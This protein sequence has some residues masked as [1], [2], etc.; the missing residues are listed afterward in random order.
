M[1]EYMDGWIG[2]SMTSAAKPISR[3][4]HE[5]MDKSRLHLAAV[6]TCT[7]DPPQKKVQ[8]Q[9]IHHNIKKVSTSFIRTLRNRIYLTAIH[10]L[11]SLPLH[12]SSISPSLCSPCFPI[13]SLPLH[14]AFPPPSPSPSSCFSFSVR[15]FDQWP[16]IGIDFPQIILGQ[17]VISPLTAQSPLSTQA[18][19]WLSVTALGRS[20]DR[21]RY[22][23]RPSQRLS[24]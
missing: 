14:P 9:S 3:R 21:L 5:F 7:D 24:D 22:F 6:K 1:D 10:R 12:L 23:R 8:P 15:Q 19:P 11:G 17:R 16:E 13:L 2:S 18:P 20:H 4:T